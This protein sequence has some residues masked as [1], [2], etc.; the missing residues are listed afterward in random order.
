MASIATDFPA[1]SV[2]SATPRKVI[3]TNI[4]SYTPEIS[5][6]TVKYAGEVSILVKI[7]KNTW[8]DTKDWSISVNSVLNCLIRTK[9]IS[10]I[11][12]SI[13]ESINFPVTN[14]ERV[15]TIA[16]G[17][18]CICKLIS[19]CLDIH[20]H[21]R[22]IYYPVKSSKWLPCVLLFFAFISVL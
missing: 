14:V 16:I 19:T 12:Q 4:C 18:C 13:L 10:S 5:L 2:I 15:L 11:Y 20:I 7:L 8:N 21:A 3:W 9:V 22:D 1:P 17:I 6:T